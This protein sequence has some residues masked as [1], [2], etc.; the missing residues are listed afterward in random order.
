[1]YIK[2]VH[3]VVRAILY[4][5]IC[6]ISV[7]VDCVAVSDTENGMQQ[8]R[9]NFK[10]DTIY[11]DVAAFKEN[12]WNETHE[13]KRILLNE[14]NCR[15]FKQNISS[16][17]E[18]FGWGIVIDLCTRNSIINHLFRHLFYLTLWKK[19]TKKCFQFDGTSGWKMN[20]P[21]YSIQLT[22]VISFVVST[23]AE[24][25]WHSSSSS[26]WYIASELVRSCLSTSSC[27]S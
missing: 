14:P 6:M 26:M 1:M 9:F 22:V 23:Q 27:P 8:K 20:I 5:R 7:I 18:L 10:T 13:M 3:F 4:G 17:S 24:Q 16:H 25:T 21:I 12:A 19:F 11:N 15:M 2:V